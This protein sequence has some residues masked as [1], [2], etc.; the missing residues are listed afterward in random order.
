[1]VRLHRKGIRRWGRWLR[2]AA[3]GVVVAGFAP[4]RAAEV[5]RIRYSS[6][7]ARTRVVVDLDAPTAFKHWTLGDPPRILITLPGSSLGGGVR[8]LQI[9][10]AAVRRLRLNTLRDGRVQIVLDL[11]GEAAYQTFTLDHPDRIVVDV[12]HDPD[13][14][15]PD[16]AGKGS[17][18]T[19]KTPDAGK[20]A[21]AE[22]EAPTGKEPAEGTSSAG[23]TAG[24]TTGKESVAASASHGASEPANGSGGGTVTPAVPPHHGPWRIAVDAGHGGKDPG[25][26]HHNTREKDIA[27]AL[28]Q[29]VVRSLNDRPG[30]SAF[31]VRKGDYFIPLRRRWT[32]AE[33]RGADIFVS[34]HCDGVRRT[35]AKGTSVY[36]LSLG[37]ASDEASRELAERE[38]AV[39]ASMGVEASGDDL[40]QILFDMV[41]TDVVSKSELLAEDCLDKLFGLGTVYS[42]GVKQAGF[43]VL[44]SPRMPSI[45]VEAAFISNPE[46]NRMLRDRKWQRSFGVHLAEGIETYCRSVT[47]SE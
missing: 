12:M 6:T 39:D 23:K 22:P 41:Q 14:T 34:I 3:L 21:P 20:N 32:S 45:L 15:A 44:K 7:E 11:T 26:S 28:A 42:R 9:G 8:P 38:N 40:D 18:G 37:G 47:P 13:R 27:L 46:E 35:S 33:E 43:A 30:M 4:A 36:F 16:P 5:Q 31:L 24:K 29:A 17:G 25:S 19:P 10:D 1:M 2:L